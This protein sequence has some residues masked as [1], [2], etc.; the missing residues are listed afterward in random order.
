MCGSLERLG[1]YWCIALMITLYRY[2][3]AV[4]SELRKSYS[5][6]KIT[7]WHATMNVTCYNDW[8][9][10]NF[11]TSSKHRNF[12]G[13]RFKNS[14]DNCDESRII[15]IF[16]GFATCVTPQ[17]EVTCYNRQ[18]NTKLWNIIWTQKNTW[19]KSGKKQ[20]L[21]VVLKIPTKTFGFQVGKTVDFVCHL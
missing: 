5:E 20:V 6:C 15:M 1:Y 4:S 2:A 17:W 18:K 19:R 11:E 9:I 13:N 10:Q 14:S 3:T 12:K 7:M 8:Q 21:T 16:Y